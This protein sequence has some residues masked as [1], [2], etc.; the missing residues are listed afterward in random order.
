MNQSS[1][2]TTADSEHLVQLFDAPRSLADAAARFLAEGW[3][4]GEQLLVVA[5]PKHWDLMAAYLESRDCRVRDEA[6]RDRVQV[7]DAVT[8]LRRMRKRG[9]F[10]AD[11]ARGILVPIVE[12]ALRQGRPLRA[13][14]ELVE[15]LAEEGD[16]AAACTVEDMW[17]ELH[18]IHRFNLLCGYSAAHFTDPRH[19]GALRN[20]CGK[21]TRVQTH[22]ADALGTWLSTSSHGH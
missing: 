20:I 9:A 17:N 8:T 19:V 12:A 7:F 3:D 14:G 5:K 6:A 10:H 21:H 18:A 16:F 2:V 15:L 1:P 11:T 13:Y 4:R 22:S